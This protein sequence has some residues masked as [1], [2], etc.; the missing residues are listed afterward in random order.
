MGQKYA[1]EVTQCSGEQMN[2]VLMGLLSSNSINQSSNDQLLQSNLNCNVYSTFNQI[3]GY[4]YSNYNP[5]LNTTQ[6]PML[7]NQYVNQSEAYSPFMWY[8]PAQS[9]SPS[10]YFLQSQL[11]QAF[12]SP[13]ILILKNA[14]YDITSEEIY[15]FLNGYEVI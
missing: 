11:M 5:T 8:Y 10:S 13:V 1:I 12:N 7:S 14:P 4:F 15:E 6:I 2:L 9:I 3:S